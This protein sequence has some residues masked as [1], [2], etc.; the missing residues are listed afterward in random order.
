MLLLMMMMRMPN[1]IKIVMLYCVQKKKE[2]LDDEY[3]K[4]CIIA[5]A[6]QM[7]F[8]LHMSFTRSAS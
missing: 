7:A 3:E 4:V 5:G 2:K 6:Q 1:A 8:R